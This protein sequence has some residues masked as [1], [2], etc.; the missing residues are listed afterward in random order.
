MKDCEKLLIAGD[1]HGNSYWATKV[2][3]YAADHGA[4]AIVQVG[5]FGMWTPGPATSSFLYRVST[6]ARDR[7]VQVYWLDGNHEDHGRRAEFSHYDNDFLTYLP[8]GTR[9][10]WFGKT[11]MALGGAVSVDKLWRTPGKSWWPEEELS[12]ADIDHAVREGDVDVI[13]SHD[14]PTGVRIP[15]LGGN[16]PPQALAEAGLHRNL[17]REVWEAKTPQLWVHGHYHVCYQ[18]WLA[19]D[20]HVFG[21]GADGDK[22]KETVMF[23]T[24]SDLP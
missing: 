22:F 18:A 17:L 14:C 16:F 7:D 4:D 13:L 20:T 6:R 24:E 23:L 5:D 1:W 21:L 8:R 2:I 11:F 19:N 12:R 9:W 10:E 15:G 3:D